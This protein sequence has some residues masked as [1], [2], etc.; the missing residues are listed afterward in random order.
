MGRPINPAIKTKKGSSSL[1]A[2]D[3]APEH[4]DQLN[5]RM[6]SDEGLINGVRRG[7]RQEM[8]WPRTNQ[9]SPQCSVDQAEINSQNVPQQ[10]VSPQ[11]QKVHP[12]RAGLSA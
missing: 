6:R 12:M 5:Q 9:N 1:A 3:I 8:G 7:V 4:A 11:K 10:S 2:V